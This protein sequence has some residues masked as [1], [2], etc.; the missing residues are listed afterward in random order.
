MRDERLRAR[1]SLTNAGLEENGKRITVDFTIEGDINNPESWLNATLSERHAYS[2]ALTLGPSLG[3]M[4]ESGGT[5]GP[6]G[7]GAV[8][9]AARG[10]CGSPWNL[11]DGN[12]K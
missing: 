12:R 1:G 9:E 10:V 5:I 2:L 8:G 11:L 3:C 4:V 7:G 6:K